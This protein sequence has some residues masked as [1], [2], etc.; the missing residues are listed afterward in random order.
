M[1][2][3]DNEVKKQIYNLIGVRLAKCGDN[4]DKGS[5]FFTKASLFL[6]E[7]ERKYFT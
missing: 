2:P 5:A 4:F 1:F 7:I 6:D 3:T